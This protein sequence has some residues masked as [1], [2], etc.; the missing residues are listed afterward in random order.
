MTTV[1]RDA[2]VRD[3]FVPAQSA[4]RTIITHVQP[5]ADARPRWPPT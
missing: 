3:R 4:W 1:V 5:D 2:P